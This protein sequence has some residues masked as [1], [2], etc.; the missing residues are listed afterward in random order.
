M[1]EGRRISASGTRSHFSTDPI[2]YNYTVW[3]A[4]HSRSICWQ[5]V[6]VWLLGYSPMEM[7]KKYGWRFPNSIT[8]CLGCGG[9]LKI[10]WTGVEG[11]YTWTVYCATDVG[12]SGV[13]I[14]LRLPPVTYH[15]HFKSQLPD[16]RGK[17]LC[18]TLFADKTQ[19]SSFGNEK[20]YPV[21]AQL[22]QL[23]QEIRNMRGLGGTQVVG[24]LP[25]VSF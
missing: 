14:S 7:G 16:P 17:P 6:G 11:V 10:W 3:K 9:A 8:F 22:C 4:T 24:W 15:Y 21:M 1:G 2:T 20:G 23:P 13:L 5:G 18:I 25:I 12:Y 19:L